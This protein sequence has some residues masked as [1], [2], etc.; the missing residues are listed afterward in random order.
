MFLATG[1]PDEGG[2]SFLER[3]VAM[4]RAGWRALVLGMAV[5]AA[6]AA[7]AD[8]PA[9]PAG[10]GEKVDGYAEWR[11]GACLVVD[12]Q[13]VCPGP[14][15]KWKGEGEARSFA[16]VPLGF[17]VKAEGTRLADGT[18]VA[19]KGEA[20]PNGS[21]MFEGEIRSATDQAE[22]RA[23]EK[24]RFLEGEEGKE[25]SV[26]RLLTEGPQVDR[27]RRIVDTLLP[28]YLHPE[29][30]R[31]YVIENK[32]WNAFAMGN[33]SIYVFTGLL[34]DMDDD[35]VAIVLGHELVHATH[36]HSRK[37]FKRDMFVQLATLG[38]L[39]ATSTIDD[40]TKQVVA[41]LAILAASSAYSSGYGRGMEDQADRVGLRYAY[42]AGYDVTKGP[43]LW[44]RF[45]KKYGEGNKVANF[46]FGDH[47]QSA[48]RA[49]K[50]EKEIAFNYPEGP[51]P[52]GPAR[53]ARVGAPASA[54]TVASAPAVPA[55][56]Q[57]LASAPVPS[58][59]TVARPA[60][61]AAPAASARPARTEIKRGMS[62]DDV[63][64][65]LGE[66]QAEVAFGAK[67]RW[68]Y[69]DLTVVFEAD[70][71]VDVRF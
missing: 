60:A 69:P 68:T 70:K 37:Q 59:V 5:L 31:I 44:N 4:T 67:T 47:S 41:G 15:L 22:Q 25:S 3:E 58:P 16:T 63:R 49:A 42:E 20:K 66:P 39:G 24:G 14:T 36:E 62:P 50:L 38:L 51:K 9:S 65:A 55:A 7:R 17:E 48:A 43:R 18:L 29:D 8:E 12:A 27:V 34:N 46:F 19:K 33:Y 21:A 32:E 56:A 61:V 10:R 57:A 23:R 53:R 11:D 28:P 45:A 1:N 26:G 54:P 2:S 52:E 40:D 71:V 64:R 13:R 6:S 30:V 35:E